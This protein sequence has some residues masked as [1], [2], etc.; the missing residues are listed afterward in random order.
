MVSTGGHHLLGNAPYNIV[1]ENCLDRYNN[2]HNRFIKKYKNM[3]AMVF[4][5]N[6]D[7]RVKFLKFPG[8][9]SGLELYAIAADIDNSL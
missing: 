1:C 3:A 9:G 6:Y 7:Q 2:N 8:L 5:D 4:G